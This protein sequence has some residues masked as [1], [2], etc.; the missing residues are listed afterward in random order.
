MWFPLSQLRYLRIVSSKVYSGLFVL[1]ALGLTACANPHFFPRARPLFVDFDDTK[2]PQSAHHALLEAKSDF[3]RA[4]HYE[5]PRFATYSGCSC[6]PR[7]KVYQGRGYRVT[8]VHEEN[9]TLCLDGPEIV[10]EPSITGGQPYRY[11][12]VDRIKE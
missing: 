6:Q 7:G 4:R 1:V 9:S 3:Q 10:L 12:E 11:S 8:M 5:T 2:V